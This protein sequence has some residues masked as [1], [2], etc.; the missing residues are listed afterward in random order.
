MGPMGPM[1]VYGLVYIYICFANSP[2]RNMACPFTSHDLWIDHPTG[3]Q[4]LFQRCLV[5]SKPYGRRV[6]CKLKTEHI[7][8]RQLIGFNANHILKR[9]NR[10]AKGVPNTKVA[11]VVKSLLFTES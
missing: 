6:S 10:L 1:K 9:L 8:E 7:L 5:S 11:E 2:L 4:S 3:R